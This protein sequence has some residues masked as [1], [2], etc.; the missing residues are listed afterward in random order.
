MNFS[1]ACTKLIILKINQ[2]LEQNQDQ[3][4]KKITS[5]ETVLA[6]KLQ[7]K[8]QRLSDL[9]A[10]LNDLMLHLDGAHKIA[11]ST[12]LDDGSVVNLSSPTRP[13]TGKRKKRKG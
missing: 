9:E 4:Q 11:Q 2:Q 10:E 5:V 13:S 6:K 3:W 7:A 12:S 8:E 1:I